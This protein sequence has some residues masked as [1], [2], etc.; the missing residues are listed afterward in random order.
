VVGLVKHARKFVSAYSSAILVGQMLHTC[1]HT[2]IHTY[3]HAYMWLGSSTTSTYGS[4][5]ALLQGAVRE[6]DDELL[7]SR[8]RALC[9]IH[10][11]RILQLVSETQAI[12]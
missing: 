7:Q 11:S 6:S 10:E 3:I 12:D 8:H 5:P 2:Y 4:A 1:I 9:V